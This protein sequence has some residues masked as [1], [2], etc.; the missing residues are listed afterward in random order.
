[1]SQRN[2]ALTPERPPLLHTPAERK[3]PSGTTPVS[4]A[5]RVIGWFGLLLAVVGLIDAGLHWFPTAFGSFE[6]EFATVAMSFGALPLATMGLAALLGSFIA[7]GIRWGIITVAVVLVIL[8]I[9]VAAALGVFMLTAPIALEAAGEPAGLTIMKAVIRT[10]T[11]G[12]GF[13][14]AYV[15][16]AAAAFRHLSP[17]GSL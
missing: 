1:M 9:L 3:V 16:G 13:G 6:W 7:R 17:K 12:V 5:W 15:I 2:T 8:A 10:G 4:S 11:M 14:L